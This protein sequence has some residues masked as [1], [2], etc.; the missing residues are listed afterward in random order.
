MFWLKLCTQK[1]VK[2]TEFTENFWPHT[3]RFWI[4]PFLQNRDRE[5]EFYL[6]IEELKLYY[7]WFQTYFSTSV[8]EFEVLLHAFTSE[9]TEQQLP[10]SPSWSAI[11]C[12]MLPFNIV[13]FLICVSSDNTWW[14]G[15]KIKSLSAIG[16]W[17]CCGRR[18]TIMIGWCVCLHCLF[19]FA[20]YAHFVW[21]CYFF[22]Q[23]TCMGGKK[24]IR[25]V[26]KGF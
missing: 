10:C 26:F 3:G 23:I 16:V 11:L 14:W 25:C 5:G 22:V 4:H 19:F 13:V 24:R 8:R 1:T 20:W 21:K 12:Y 17:C 2:F 15:T 7:V 6:L 9:E 18:I